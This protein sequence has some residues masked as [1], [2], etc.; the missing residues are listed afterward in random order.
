MTDNTHELWQF[1]NHK[2]ECALNGHWMEASDDDCTC[3][4][5]EALRSQ[6]PTE[7]LEAAS[8]DVGTPIRSAYARGYY[9][10]EKAACADLTS[11][12]ATTPQP[13]D[14]LLREARDWMKELRDKPDVIA[15]GVH[16]GLRKGTDEKGAH[17]AWQAVGNI[18]GQGWL[19]AVGFAVDP[20]FSMWGGD[21]II[22]RIDQHLQESKR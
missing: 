20:F 5:A 17:E 21:K 8:V 12:Q 7:Q 22:A 3:G 4:L 19:H 10:G 1:I 14:E 13:Q 9:E 6:T 16:A 2:P 15:E 18:Q 11:L